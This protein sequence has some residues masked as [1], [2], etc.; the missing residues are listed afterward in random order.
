MFD[1]PANPPSLRHVDRGAAAE[2]GEPPRILGP[3]VTAEDGGGGGDGGGDGMFGFLRG[4]SSSAASMLPTE[5]FGLGSEPAAGACDGNGPAAVVAGAPDGG[6]LPTRLAT[7]LPPMDA[8]AAVM[9]GPRPSAPAMDAVAAVMSGPRPS[10]AERGLLAEPS[11]AVVSAELLQPA[12][13]LLASTDM[14][15]ANGPASMAVATVEVEPPR[16]D[17]L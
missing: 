2:P 12:P 17:E 5:I 6:R 9:S 3:G 8:V 1:N 13:V 10:A 4:P 11:S 15:P 7:T 16:T 14:V